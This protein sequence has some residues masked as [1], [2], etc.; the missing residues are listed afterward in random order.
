MISDT[1]A[2]AG[3]LYE[4]SDEEVLAAPESDFE[5]E[6]DENYEDGDNEE[7]SEA[8]V[9][10]DSDEADGVTGV[11]RSFKTRQKP[12]EDEFDGEGWGKSK[13]DYYNADAIETEGDAL[14]E[15][16]E[17]L[18]LQR[19]QLEGMTDADFG[20][21]D[22]DW[23]DQTGENDA[24][25]EGITH[26]ILPRLELSDAT[27]MEERMRIVNTGYPELRSLAGEF[28]DLQPKLEQ[29]HLE[30]TVTESHGST[31]DGQNLP[32]ATA[33]WVSL[34]AYLAAL[35]M[36]FA[37]VSAGGRGSDN[38]SNARPPEELRKHTIMEYLLRWRKAWAA[39]KDVPAASF[40]AGTEGRYGMVD[41]SGDANG[42]R[43][44]A[45]HTTEE[46]VVNGGVPKRK[47][48]RRKSQAQRAAE[49]A[50]AEADAQRRERLREMQARLAKLAASDKPGADSPLAESRSHA[51]QDSDDSDLG[52]ETALAEHEAA[53]KAKRKKSLRFYTAQI[54]QKANKRD[55]ARR[56]AGG[57]TDVP[58]RERFRDRQMRLN[59][60]ARGK[61][62]YQ[63]SNA[64]R[65]DGNSDDEDA[66][67]ATAGR[68]AADDDY[69]AQ[70]AAQTRA[71]AADK[72]VRA[73]AHRDAGSIRSQRPPR[74]SAGPDSKRG[75]SYAIEKNRGITPSG[76]RNV[77][78]PRVKKR[79]RYDDKLK[80]L[81]SVRPVYKGGE[82]R[83]GY[84]GELTGIKT[85][86]VKS[87]KF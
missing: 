61:K 46:A 20:L 31:L 27:S 36:Y 24:A 59:A 25:E 26:E 42:T 70:I 48:R 53:E 87:V 58:Y 82:G 78:N 51:V 65:L 45:L 2:R 30:A 1:N 44:Y 55:S 13:R 60:E 9:A 40:K 86:L 76:K 85:N 7:G 38:D 23:A 17:A 72:A 57:D 16:E 41:G 12:A 54:A 67:A 50:L 81:N 35:S 62:N 29:L 5:G 68:Q 32:V 11:P 19:K 64:A 6:T 3:K 15:E 22:A 66:A 49:D 84:G 75:L 34:S 63:Q 52:E 79:R 14:E 4:P 18:K 8:E 71:K 37:L 33:K 28:L 47:K 69:Y 74:E 80:K 21:D 39:L 73:Q 10:S 43:T 77:R 83:G 56:N